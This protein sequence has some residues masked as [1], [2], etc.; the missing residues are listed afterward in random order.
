MPSTQ[1]SLSLWA[2]GWG[3]DG[4]FPI[5]R[6]VPK[7]K[8][9]HTKN[10]HTKWLSK[11]ATVGQTYVCGEETPFWRPQP[12]FWMS[13][14]DGG[15]RVMGSSAFCLIITL[16][17]GAMVQC[18]IHNLIQPPKLNGIRTHNRSVR[19]WLICQW[20]RGDL[21]APFFGQLHFRGTRPLVQ[22]L[23][24]W[25]CGPIRSRKSS[26]IYLFSFHLGSSQKHGPPRSRCFGQKH[27]VSLQQDG[28]PPI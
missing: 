10:I 27:S 9:P 26:T 17:V 24:N 3:V 4:G 14:G 1:F 6:S 7:K 23:P 2:H 5:N 21:A 8:L 22:A 11:S 13:R 18:H 15:P 20:T 25:D 19:W 12:L 28:A 16:I